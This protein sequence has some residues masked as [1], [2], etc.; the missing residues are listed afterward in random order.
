M[1]TKQCLAFFLHRQFK[2][3]KIVVDWKNALINQLFQQCHKDFH[4]L[5]RG[6]SHLQERTVNQVKRGNCKDT[7]LLKHLEMWLTLGRHLHNI[8]L[9]QLIKYR[10]GSRFL[11]KRHFVHNICRVSK[12][13]NLSNYLMTGTNFAKKYFDKNPAHDSPS[14]K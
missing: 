11:P 13:S 14:N 7:L 9:G 5:F 1:G 4:S 2:I 6:W 12:N 3:I 8:P 10:K